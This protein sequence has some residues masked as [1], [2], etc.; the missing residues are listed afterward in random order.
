MSCVDVVFVS[1]V[2]VVLQPLAASLAATA[3]AARSSEANASAASIGSMDSLHDV[4]ARAAASAGFTIDPRAMFGRMRR[5]MQPDEQRSPVLCRACTHEPAPLV[6]DGLS[7]QIRRGLS[8]ERF[9]NGGHAS[10]CASVIDEPC[11]NGMNEFRW[12]I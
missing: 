8:A 1:F 5:G 11:R 12:K 4:L 7:P 9:A 3:Y 2:G 10:Q 6:P